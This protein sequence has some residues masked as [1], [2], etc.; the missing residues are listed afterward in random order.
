M[1]MEAAIFNG[2]AV[3][4]HRPHFRNAEVVGQGFNATG[5]EARQIMGWAISS[6]QCHRRQLAAST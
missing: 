5:L 4:K 2:I 6:R 3:T 1:G